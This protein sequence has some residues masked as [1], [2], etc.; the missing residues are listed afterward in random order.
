MAEA[1]TLV[2]DYCGRPAAETLKIRAG[3]RNYLLDVCSKHLDD[4]KSM[5]RKPRR[6]RPRTAA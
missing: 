1:T 3:Q 5:A 4:I 2:C 6:G